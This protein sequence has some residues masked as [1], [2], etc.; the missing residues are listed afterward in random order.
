[1]Q[2]YE[3]KNIPKTGVKFEVANR[4]AIVLDEHLTDEDAEFLLDDGKNSN[5]AHYIKLKE[6]PPAIVE[7]IP[8]VVVE[9]KAVVA[10]KSKEV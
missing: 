3:L 10:G 8:P 5:A 1:M 4:R 6:I 7:Q 9:Q 2:K